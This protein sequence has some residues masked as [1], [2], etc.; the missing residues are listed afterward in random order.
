M[1][2]RCKYLYKPL[3]ENNCNFFFFFLRC[4]ICFKNCLNVEKNEFLL[5]YIFHF[6]EPYESHLCSNFSYLKLQHG[7]PF[8]LFKN[9]SRLVLQAKV[10]FVVPLLFKA[11][12]GS[13]GGQKSLPK[14]KNKEINKIPHSE[15][16]GTC[17]LYI[18]TKRGRTTFKTKKY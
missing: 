6:N 7:N 5:L 14:W 1:L 17:V 15:S 10:D 3:E 12:V 11:P 16:D 9:S 18:L 13:C 4:Y 2:L 8:Y